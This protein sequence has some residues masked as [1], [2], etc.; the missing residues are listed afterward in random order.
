MSFSPSSLLTRFRA[1]YT[2]LAD[3]AEQIVAFARWMRWRICFWTLIVEW[4]G[5]SWREVKRRNECWTNQITWRL[6]LRDLT[7]MIT[8]WIGCMPLTW[9]LPLFVYAGC[10]WSRLCAHARLAKQQQSAIWKRPTRREWEWE[11]KTPADRQR[12]TAREQR[13]TE[14]K[15]EPSSRKLLAVVFFFS[16]FSRYI[17]FIGFIRASWIR[18]RKLII[19]FFS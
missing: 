7:E 8:F 18:E 15:N 4:N 1:N 3:L 13:E 17:F 14:Y 11:K 16:S 5:S 10:L 6:R 2:Y 12:P 19:M 9:S